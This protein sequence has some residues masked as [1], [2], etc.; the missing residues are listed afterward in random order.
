[1]KSKVPAGARVRLAK[2]M[3]QKLQERSAVLYT[4]ELERW[5]T[6]PLSRSRQSS[7]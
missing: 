2:L 5:N 4:R 7:I 6:R 1:M 3:E